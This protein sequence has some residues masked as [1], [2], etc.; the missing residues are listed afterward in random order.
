M[1]SRAYHSDEDIQDTVGFAAE[2]SCAPV[3]FFAGERICPP[4]QS[5][6][7]RSALRAIL[8]VTVVLGCAFGWMSLSGEWKDRIMARVEAA[9]ARATRPADKPA[10]PQPEAATLADTAP[11]PALPEAREIAAAPAVEAGV[12]VPSPP[13]V[14]AAEEEPLP[15]PAAAKDNAPPKPLPP[16]V[17]DPADPNQKR[18]LAVGLHP[19]L[20]RALLSR[21]SDADYRNAGVAI[22]AALTKTP[23]TQVYA[24]PKD[25]GGAKLALFEVSFVRGASELC[26]RYVVTVT[27]ARWSTTALPMEKCGIR[28]PGQL[29]RAGV[30]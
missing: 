25:G 30:N 14:V 10:T 19:D 4:G 12:A 18:A 2:D 6:R 24:W 21:L 9:M 28:K 20:S 3:E 7:R 15:D 13:S 29:V 23:D 16:P 17:V 22:K 11:A 26:R 8:F 27:L 5:G 1:A